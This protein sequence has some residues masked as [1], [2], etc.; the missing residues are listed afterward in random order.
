MLLPRLMG[1]TIDV[2]KLVSSMTLFGNLAK[3]L[4]AGE[5]GDEY[6]ALARAADD[7]LAVAETEG[8]APCRFTLGRL[9]ERTKN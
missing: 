6:A 9:A 1:S 4:H 2:T 7:I 5:G 8:Y 3:Q